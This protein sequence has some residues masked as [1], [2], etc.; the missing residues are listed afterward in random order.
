MGTSLAESGTAPRGA[1]RM[2]SDREIPAYGE[3]TPELLD[4]LR[5]I[6]GEKNVLTEPAELLVYECD[7]YTLERLPPQAVVLPGNT[8]EVSQVLT[9]LYEAGVPF[10]PRGAGTSLAGSTIAV[11]GGV[12]VGLSRMRRIREIDL[13]NRIA[14]LEAGVVNIWVTQAVEKEGF[15][16]APDPS[17]Q[18][19]CT[20]GGNVATNAGGPHTLK[21]GV[22]LNHVL[23]VEM[24][25][26]DGQ[27]VQLGGRAEDPFGYDLT[28]FVVGSEGTLGLV[29]QV[30]VRLT[31]APQAYRTLLAIFDSVDDATQTVSA[32]IRQGIVPAAVE[33]MDRLIIQAVEEAYHFGFPTDAAAVLIIELDGLEAG[34]DALVSQVIGICEEHRAREIRRAR[35]E[36]ERKALWASRKRAFGAV[37]RLSPSFVTQ[38]GVV[39]RTKLPE[40]LRIVTAVGAKYNLRVANVFHA[41]DGNIHPLI[42]FDENDPDQVERVLAASDEILN[43]CIDLGGSVTGEHGIGIEKIEHLARMFTPEDLE[44]MTRLQDAFDPHDRCNPGKLF[45]SSKGC[46]E[47][48]RPRPKAPA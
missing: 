27:V 4:A 32:I 37:G 25:L 48:K 16:Y 5:A 46:I 12:I 24:V 20:I 8:D 31:R 23:G 14:V 29:T 11:R 30:T 1:E 33:M 35:T 15:F 2:V 41:G 19:A 28:G 22:T 18:G 44:V 9:L 36:A 6:V 47:V 42:L 34:I 17:S 43:A 26:A 10:I 21:Y 38:D 13:A 40:I 3:V 45:P 7:G 39:P